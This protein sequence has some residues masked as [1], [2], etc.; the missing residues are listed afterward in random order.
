VEHV[1]LTIAGSDPSG[2][3]GI[4]ADIKTFRACGVR[5]LSLITALTAQNTLG[6]QDILEIP[7]DFI[8]SQFDAILVNLRPDA[9]KTGMLY[10]EATV[11]ITASK[12]K[13]YSLKNLVVDPVMSST[14]GTMLANSL[15]VEALKNDLLPLSLVLTPNLKEA[16]VLAQMPVN[17]LESMKQAARRILEF[18]PQAVII[19]GGHLLKAPVDLLWDGKEFTILEGRRVDGS[20]HGTGCTFSASL[21]ACLSK[22]QSLVLAFR[23]ARDFVQKALETSLLTDSAELRLL[24][25]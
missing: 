11:N 24:Q 9:L 10:N 22:G 17:D 13:E 4:Q 19:T 14:T 2:G 23:T 12:I 16:S 18:G 1:A 25:F 6:I 3:A 8:A 5:D 20:F 15:A 7:P 21:T